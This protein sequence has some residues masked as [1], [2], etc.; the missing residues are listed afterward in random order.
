MLQLL[1][2]LVIKNFKSLRQIFIPFI[3]ATSVMLGL[4]Y[5]MLSMIANE[6]IQKRHANLPQL[7]VYSNVLVG[8]L[9]VVFIIYANRFVMKQRKQEFALNMVLGLEKKHI[10]FILLLESF[11]QF[12]V[13]SILSVCGGYLFGNLVFLLMNKL[14]KSKGMSL[15][16][17]PFDVKSALLTI[18]ILAGVMVILFIFNNISLTLQSPIQLMRSQLA[19]EKKTPKWLLA[20]LF[21]IGATALGYGY[22][23]ALTTKGVLDS[24]QNIFTAILS[25]MIGTYF[26]FMS[27]TIIVLQLLKRNKNVYYKP[28]QFFSISGLLSRMKSNAVGLA[29]ITMLMTFLM[30]TLGMSLSAYRGIE[31]QIAGSMTHQYQINLY[32][33]Q[34]KQVKNIQ[35]DISKIADVDKFRYSELAFFPIIKA[36]NELVPLNDQIGPKLKGKDMTYIVLTTEKD[37]NI[38][39]DTAVKVNDGEIIVSTNADRYSHDKT[40]KIEGQQV[41]VKS[42]D[43]NYIGNQI[44][45]DAMYII[46]KDK[47]QFETYRNYFK[48]L[49]R[50]TNKVEATEASS[51][52]AFNV[53]RHDETFKRAIPAL[54]KEHGIRIEN[55][56]DTQKTIYEMNGG[57]IFIGIVVSITLLTGVFLV[58]Y[59]KQLSEGYEDKRNYSIMQKVGLP[60]DLIKKTINKQIIWIFGLPIIVT[61]IHTLFASKIIF[62][63]LGILGV[64]DKTMF[65][66]SYGIVVLVIMVIYGVMYLVTS[67]TYYKIINDK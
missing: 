62:N 15:M 31:A 36:G 6:Y 29:S 66:T 16:D 52:L 2:K 9:T 14:V 44:A 46:V 40:L 45:I 65:F 47:A 56:D 48:S 27:L 25:V 20:V 13:I 23:I 17:Y 55:K 24:L 4:Q 3:L 41:K 5:I 42:A 61:V 11:L 59:Y 8:I 49:N 38:A 67:R 64:R 26:L 10:R 43:Q 58:L 60:Q 30:V 35:D 1:S 39:H 54:Q 22:N 63:L 21:I 19:G 32:G 34:K 53:E 12:I 33:P 18:A 57:L 28:N 51:T 7:L 37:H 50:E